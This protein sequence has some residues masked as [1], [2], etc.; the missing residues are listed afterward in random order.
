M[1]SFEVLLH[2]H[3]YYSVCLCVDDMCE[4]SIIYARGGKSTA[5]RSWFFPYAMGHRNQ[6]K[7]SRFALQ[8]PSLLIHLSVPLCV[9]LCL[10]LYAMCIYMNR[11][12]QGPLLFIILYIHTLYEAWLVNIWPIL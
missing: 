5:F 8:V 12:V 3:F 11:C 2:M 6:I 4:Y 1:L 7:V 10:C 9:C